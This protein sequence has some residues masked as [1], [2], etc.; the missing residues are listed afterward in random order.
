MDPDITLV[1]AL[2]DEG[3]DD[4]AAAVESALY[5]AT[6]EGTSRKVKISKTQLRRIIE[7]YS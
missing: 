7:N 2:K 4:E 3:M 5:A 1:D 6:N